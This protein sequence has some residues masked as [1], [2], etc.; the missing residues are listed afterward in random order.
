VRFKKYNSPEEERMKIE[1]SIQLI[2][3][4]VSD[5]ERGYVPPR[6]QKEPFTDEVKKNYIS[7][8]QG[9]ITRLKSKILKTAPEAKI[10][11]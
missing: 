4:L 8:L 2:V 5:V 3:S 7:Y 11:S 1:A 6:F 10:P 9:E